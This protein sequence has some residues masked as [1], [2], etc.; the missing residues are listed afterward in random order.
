MPQEKQKST[1]S[2]PTGLLKRSE[3]VISLGKRLVEEL[4]L[5]PSV[6]TLGR[7][8]AHY[9]A[10]LIKK[11][12]ETNKPAE[13]RMAMKI[14]CETI[15]RLWKHRS[16]LPHGARPLGNLES[17]LNAIE[18]LREKKLPWLR[19]PKR[20]IESFAGP[21]MG[22]AQ[23]VEETGL[24]ICK[25]AVL[26]AIAER[27]FAKEK[28]WLRDHKE[29]L[30]KGEIRVIQT[31]DSWLSGGIIW[32]TREDRVSIGDLEPHERVKR[33]LSEIESSIKQVNE[34]FESLRNGVQ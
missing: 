33:M 8:M 22:Y 28:R 25:M 20:E 7:W 5:E 9:I 10:E 1:S 27:G 2:T 11:A 16:S 31:L 23:V 29:M 17:V 26:M 3:N 24:R 13:R 12:D 21:W 18:N 19:L 14:C 6:D 4:G 15:L 32:R 30:S 34:A